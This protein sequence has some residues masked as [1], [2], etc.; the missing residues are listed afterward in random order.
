VDDSDRILEELKKINQTLRT[1]DTDTWVIVLLI[2]A[3]FAML[4]LRA[5]GLIK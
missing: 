1:I 3:V 4:V 5:F 2:T